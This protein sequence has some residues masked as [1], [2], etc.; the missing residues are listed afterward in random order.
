MPAYDLERGEDL[1]LILA[2]APLKVTRERTPKRIFFVKRR[3]PAG[4][5]RVQVRP[6]PCHKVLRPGTA[7]LGGRLQRAGFQWT[8]GIFPW[9]V[10]IFEEEM[11]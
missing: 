7:P 11:V 9:I 6:V 1:P 10:L 4:L 3:V 8:C 5:R 2:R